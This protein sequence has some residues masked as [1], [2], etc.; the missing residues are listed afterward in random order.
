MTREEI[1]E[2]QEN[3]NVAKSFRNAMLATGIVCAA[4]T[5]GFCMTGKYKEACAIGPMVGICGLG[6]AIGNKDIR[7]T[8]KVLSE[9]Q[10]TCA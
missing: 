10:K 6:T 9:Q 7:A 1:A 4:V 3:Y 5:I 8:Q 2:R